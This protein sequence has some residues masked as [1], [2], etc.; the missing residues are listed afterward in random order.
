MANEKDFY[1]KSKTEV[2]DN[3][4]LAEWLRTLEDQVKASSVKK[5]A[6]VV[7]K[8]EVKPA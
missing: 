4:E 8:S 3:K 6:A 5:S 1:A 2:L 7:K